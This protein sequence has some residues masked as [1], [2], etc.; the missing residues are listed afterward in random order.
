MESVS[1]LEAEI[2]EGTHILVVE[3]VQLT[4]VGVYMYKL[5]TVLGETAV[6][7]LEALV[8]GYETSTGFR[9]SSSA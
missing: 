9:E 7:R 5:V 6:V 3:M 2:L 4:A 8:A 1:P